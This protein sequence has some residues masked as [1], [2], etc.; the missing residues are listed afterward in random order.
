VQIV[1]RNTRTR[2]SYSCGR[3]PRRSSARSPDV[4]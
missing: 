1:R 4:R 3:Q 2:E